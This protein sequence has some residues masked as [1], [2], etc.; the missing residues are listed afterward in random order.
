MNIAS[1]WITNSNS[2]ENECGEDNTHICCPLDKQ[3]QPQYVSVLP[4]PGECGYHPDSKKIFGGTEAELDEFS[5]MGILQYRRNAELK[6]ACS[7]SLIN[8]E[9]LITAAHCVDPSAVKDMGYD[10]L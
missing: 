6:Q 4:L 1:E 5:W 10:K 9:Y 2:K 8:R 3:N 7:G